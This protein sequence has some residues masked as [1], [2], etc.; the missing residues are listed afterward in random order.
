MKI[1]FSNLIE[2]VKEQVP[3]YYGNNRVEPSTGEA[4][5]LPGITVKP[6]RKT[7]KIVRQM[8]EAIPGKRLR[9]D[10]YNWLDRVDDVS[11]HT[12][13]LRFLEIYRKSNK[14][15]ISFTRKILPKQRSYYNGLF[16]SINI[17]RV[18]K[19]YFI[20]NPESYEYKHG[21]DIIQELAH[22]YQYNN[23]TDKYNLKGTT[24]ISQSFEN[25]YSN[26]AGDKSPSIYET[27]GTVEYNAHKII[28]PT[29]IDYLIM[30][31]DSTTN[32]RKSVHE[33]YDLVQ[34]LNK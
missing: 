3:T 16:N 9:S 22:A 2:K 20:K 23:S 21:D 28:A 18:P 29:I 26:I 6:T 30:D 25:L 8:K 10:M 11:Q 15:S 34:R 12:A 14:P 1:D 7:K 4:G 31:E 32:F 17:M 24:P 27:P 19:E 13:A 33:N 5:E